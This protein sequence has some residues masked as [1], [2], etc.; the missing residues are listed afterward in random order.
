MLT[1]LH[2]SNIVLID[3][4]DIRFSQGLCVLT[5]ETGAGKSIMLDALGLILGNRADTGLIRQGQ[6]QAQV[7]AAFDIASNEEAKQEL[8]ALDLPLEDEIIIRRTVNADGK[9]KCFINDAPVSAAALK[10]LAACLVEIHGQHDQRGLFDTG[11]HRRILDAY[12][13]NVTL[14]KQVNESYEVWQEAERS[15]ARAEAEIEKA[16]K[17]EEYLKHIVA[18]LGALRPEAGEE[19]DLSDKRNIMMQSEKLFSVLNE[20]LGELMK[21]GGASATLRSVQRTLLRSSLTQTPQFEP[22]IDMLDKASDMAGEVE[23]ALEKV[24]KQAEYDPQVLEKME[25]R[26]F[27]I[28]AAARKYHVD[29][30]SLPDVLSQAQE[31]LKKLTQN[32]QCLREVNKQCNATKAEFK[33]H[34]DTLSA[35][36]RKAAAKL[37]K[38]VLKELAPL[39]ME[40]TAFRVNIESLEETQW[41]RHGAD[42]VAMQVATNV[43]KGT[44]PSFS[45]LQKIASGGELSRFMLALKVALSDVRFTPTMI[46]DE[47]DTGTGG[48]VADAIG[49]RLAQLGATAQVLVVTH[50]PQVAARGSQHMV[51]SKA[52]KGKQITTHIQTLDVGARREELARMLAGEVITAEARKAADKLLEHA[53]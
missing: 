48:A 36:R 23:A 49:K 1:Q 43:T 53:A 29:A 30:D 39:K 4:A 50:L 5:G 51:V 25:E 42:A 40:H 34:A 10:Q 11:N 32:E 2:I 7:A 41:G 44:A 3:Q 8:A 35:A 24:G 31:A 12:G 14:L 27:A 13:A 46:F 37:E 20:A 21:E 16:R 52:A 38:A 19:Q 18:D 26:L 33:K 17:E 22:I 9:G 47:I 45:P 6:A 15:R 28:R